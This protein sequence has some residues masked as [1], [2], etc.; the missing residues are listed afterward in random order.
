MRSFALT[1][2][3]WNS[4]PKKEATWAAYFVKTDLARIDNAVRTG[5]IAGLDNTEIA[6][7]VIGS[8]GL[9]GVDG[10]T[11]ITSQQ[12]AHIGRIALKPRRKP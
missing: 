10:V 12:I 2:R 5:L 7:R 4:A 8:V 11:E 3:G 1:V 6:R 9:R